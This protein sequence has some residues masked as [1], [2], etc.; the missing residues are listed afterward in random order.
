LLDRRQEIWRTD[1]E[2]RDV[3]K[4]AT[5]RTSTEDAA[6]RLRA[7]VARISRRLQR[8][9]S[10]VPLTPTELAVLSS[11]ARTGP[12]GLG[13][14]AAEEA[15]N[16][17]MLSRVVHRLEGAGLLRREEDPADRR[18]ARVMATGQGRHLLERIRTEKADA[19]NRALEH[20]SPTEQARLA[21]ALPVLETL[22]E[23]LRGQR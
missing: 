12:V 11:A 8:A 15:M 23:S 5:P 17:T 10:G 1:D 13:R 18:A 14:L 7:V 20:L 19:L 6:T 16:P 4:Q 2:G 21:D 22:A 9:T 3:T